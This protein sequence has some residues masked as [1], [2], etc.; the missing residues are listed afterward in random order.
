MSN[1]T[2]TQ[3]LG[4]AKEGTRLTGESTAAKFLT[5]T[6]FNLQEKPE[7]F[8]N[9]SAFGRRES[10]LSVNLAQKVVEGDLEAVLDMDTIGDYLFYATGSVSSNTVDGATTHVFSTLQ[11]TEL[12]T[13]SGFYERGNASWL[14]S[15]GTC[16][17]ELEISAEVGTDASMVKASLMAISEASVASQTPSYTKPTNVINSRHVTMG[18]ADNIAGLSSATDY[19]IKSVKVVLKNNGEYDWKLGSVNP[20]NAFA[21]KFEAEVEFTAVMSNADFDGFARN[22]TSKALQIL[23]L[24]D[25]AA[26]IGSS[27]NKPQLKIE[28]APCKPVI[29]YQLGIDDIITFDCVMQCEYS[30]TDGFIVRPTLINETASY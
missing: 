16:I 23:F 22:G 10:N 4:I 29:T 3:D 30:V 7:Y 5:Y 6:D 2:R 24:N 14:R 8:K 26:N 17:N 18:Y 27:S 25:Q 11:N 1:L 20:A 28:V 21:R 13:F 12:P 19:A 15:V 9:N